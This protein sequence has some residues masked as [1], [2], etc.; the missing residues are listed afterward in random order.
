MGKVK[1]GFLTTYDQTVFLKQEPSR[2]R[3]GRWVLWYTNVIFHNAPSTFLGRDDFRFKNRHLY[4]GKVSL[5]ECFLFLAHKIRS[6]DYKV[7]NTM[8]DKHWI[9]AA[10][11]ASVGSRKPKSP[12][13]SDHISDSDE[14]SGSESTSGSPTGAPT[15]SKAREATMDSRKDSRSSRS[16]AIGPTTRS[17]AT[18]PDDLSSRTAHLSLADTSAH[19]TERRTP[20]PI[21]VYA[22]SAQYYY[23]DN[24]KRAVA[25]TLFRDKGTG[26]YYFTMNGHNYEAN[27]V[28]ARHDV[29][30]PKHEKRRK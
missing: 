13:D 21:T 3:P 2:Q 30:E 19:D 24:H 20:G 1:Y 10:I 22:D 16:A 27:L 11:G 17:R 29:P 8:N 15:A 12:L 18:G 7:E 28:Q 5:R 25:V 4:G 26:Q 14:S 6:G 23:L 9:G